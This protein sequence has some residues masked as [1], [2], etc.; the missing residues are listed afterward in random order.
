MSDGRDHDHEA[1]SMWVGSTRKVRGQ[2]AWPLEHHNDISMR[3]EP[4]VVQS[5]EPKVERISVNT[6]QSARRLQV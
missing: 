5:H 2:E 3:E 4:M 6:C 1:M